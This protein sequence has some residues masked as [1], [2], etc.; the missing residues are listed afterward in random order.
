MRFFASPKG[1]AVKAKPSPGETQWSWGPNSGMSAAIPSPNARTPTDGPTSIGFSPLLHKA[2]SSLTCSTILEP[3]SPRMARGTRGYAVTIRTLWCCRKVRSVIPGCRDGR[4]SKGRPRRRGAYRRRRSFRTGHRRARDH[5]RHPQVPGTLRSL[6][7]RETRS[8][9]DMGAPPITADASPDR[10]RHR[11]LSPPS[12]T[13]FLTAPPVWS[14]L[15]W[16]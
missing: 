8:A 4:R 1:W 14:E 7:K 11:R 12:D 16:R 10:H 15:S 6:T 5:P 9:L 2:T 3:T 13:N